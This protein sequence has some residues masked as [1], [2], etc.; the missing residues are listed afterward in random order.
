MREFADTLLKA[1]PLGS[2]Q[3]QL[4]VTAKSKGWGNGL[5][6]HTGNAPEVFPRADGSLRKAPLNGEFLSHYNMGHYLGMPFPI[7]ID[8]ESYWIFDPSG[9]LIELDIW[10][11]GDLP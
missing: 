8:V 6:L 4:A 10:K 7:R 1:V 9:K 3:A 5:L 11:V 2:T